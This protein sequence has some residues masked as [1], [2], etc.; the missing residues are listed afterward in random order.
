MVLDE[1]GVM[2]VGAIPGIDDPVAFVAVAEKGYATVRL[3][4]H[5]PSGHSNSPP[6]R[7]SIGALAN[8]LSRLEASPMD[9][10][11]RG[12]T[13]MMM[14][15]LAPHSSFGM[16]I[17]LANLW[18]FE[19]LVEWAMTLQPATAATVRTT[20]AITMVDAGIKDNVLSAT[21]EATVNFRI[22]PGET[23]D[24]VIAHVQ[25]VI[26]DDG[27]DVECTSSCWGP[28]EVSDPNTEAFATLE[29]SIRQVFGDVIVTPMLSIGGTDARYY[30]GVSDNVYRFL[31]ARLEQSDMH[32]IHGTDERV[33]VDNVGD[34]V[35]FYATFIRNA[36][37]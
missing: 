3:I 35:R 2:M 11:L 31:P 27:I 24:D 9:T 1:G 23:V 17:A 15:R 4:A 20:T 12:P 21:A 36:A 37:G 34:A 13:R 16:R 26:D 32:R 25:D 18:L 30:G 33:A 7:T 19:P 29:A 5:G 14:D 10:D 8:A 6:K 22:L 28:S